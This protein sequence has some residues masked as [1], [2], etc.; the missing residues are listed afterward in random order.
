MPRK[1][2]LIVEDEYLLALNLQTVLEECGW[3]VIGPAASVRDALALLD[4]G[5]PLVAILD[6]N[7]GYETV[8]PVAEFLKDHHVPFAL[9]TAYPKPEQY[10]GQI[11]AG[12]PNVGKPT[13]DRRLLATIKQLVGF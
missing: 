6:V 11:L 10:G 7:L 12:V 2:I 13:D 4:H 3:E 1:T 5:L 8:T 9:A